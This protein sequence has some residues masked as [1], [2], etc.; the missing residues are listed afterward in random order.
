MESN[1]NNN[2]N[3]HVESLDNPNAFRPYSFVLE[4][5]R[6]ELGSYSNN[7]SRIC[8]HRRLS[9]D[10]ILSS[11]KSCIFL[12]H[13]Y[14]L[15]VKYKNRLDR[16]T[17]CKLGF[18]DFEAF[19]L[20][21]NK[22]LVSHAESS[23][24]SVTSCKH[25]R[26]F[27]SLSGASASSECTELCQHFCDNAQHLFECSSACS[28]IRRNLFSGC[29]PVG[30]WYTTCQAC[31]ATCEFASSA[32]LTPVLIFLHSLKVFKEGESLT[33]TL[34]CG[35]G[36]VRLNTDTFNV[37]CDVLGYNLPRLGQMSCDF[38]VDVS[39]W[40]PNPIAPSEHPSV[41]YH[42]CCRYAN[43]E[44]GVTSCHHTF[45]LYGTGGFSLE[46]TET[47]H[48]FLM[49][50]SSC[51][52]YIE[53][54]VGTIGL[55]NFGGMRGVI[56]RCNY[57]FGEY[58]RDFFSGPHCALSDVPDPVLL[59][60]VPREHVENSQNVHYCRAEMESADDSDF[61]EDEFNRAVELANLPELETVDTTEADAIDNFLSSGGDIVEFSYEGLVVGRGLGLK[62]RIGGLLKGVAN[63]IKKLHLVW[64]YP[65]DKIVDATEATGNWLEENKSYVS[66][67]VWACQQC[68]EV[69]KDISKLAKDQTEALA[70]LRKGLEKLSKAVD[71]VVNAQNENGSTL[72]SGLLE[73]MDRI[74][75]TTKALG[76]ELSKLDKRIDDM[77]SKPTVGEGSRRDELR[78]AELERSMA[79]LKKLY[80]L[81]S[82]SNDGM[83]LPLNVGGNSSSPVGEQ[84][85]IPRN[86]TKHEQREAFDRMLSDPKV[87]ILP[88]HTVMD[89][90]PRR[91]NLSK[92]MERKG[93][94]FEGDEMISNVSIEDTVIATRG[95]DSQH[96]AMTA[97]HLIGTI[98]W[99][100]SDG[101]NNVISSIPFPSTLFKMNPRLRRLAENF[102]YY[103][104][105]GFEF[106]LSLTSVAMQGGTLLVAWDNVDSATRQNADT[107]I[108]LSG[109]PHV[110]IHASSN[111][112][113]RLYVDSPSLQAQMCSLGSEYSMN[114]LGSLKV[115]C[116]N[117]LNAPTD[118]SQTVQINV[119]V[120]FVEPIFSLYGKSA[121][122]ADRQLDVSALETKAFGEVSCVVARGKWTTTS[123]TN[124]MSLVVHPC[125]CHVENQ[126]VYQTPL[127]VIANAFARWRG[128]LRYRF[129]FGASAF[130]KGRL[131]IAAV[132]VQFRQSNMSLDDMLTYPNEVF[133]LSGTNLVAEVV[134]PYHS[135]GVNSFVNRD[136]IYDVASYDS[137]LVTTRLHVVVLDPLVLNANASNSISYFVDVRPGTDFVLSGLCGV[138]AEY[139]D[140]TIPQASFPAGL[141][142]STLIG[143][144]FSEM[145][146]VRSLLRKFSLDDARRNTIGFAVSPSWR[147]NAPCV[148]MLNWI[149]QLFTQWRGDLQYTLRAHSFNKLQG[150]FVR[151]W[152]DPNGSVEGE[153]EIEYLSDVEPSSGAA[154]DYWD[155]SKGELVFTVP[156]CA[157]TEKLILPKA[158]Y[159]PTSADWIQCYNG[160]VYVDFEGSG[161]INLELSIAG[162]GAFEMF[163]R[164]VAP[165]SGKVTS[166]FTALSY[167]KDLLDITDPQIFDRKRLSGPTSKAIVTPVVKK[168]IPA[169]ATAARSRPRHLGHIDDINMKD[170]I[171][172]DT[173]DYDGEL[174]TWDGYEWTAQAGTQGCFGF[175]NLKKQ[176]DL[177]SE[178]NTCEKIV[179]LVENAHKLM[180]AGM[181]EGLESKVP[182]IVE[183]LSKL[184]KIIG[185][186][187]RGSGQMESSLHKFSSMREKIVCLLKPFIKSSIPGVATS[188][189]QEEKYTWAAIISMVGIT[190]F[191]ISAKTVKS[192]KKKCAIFLMIVWA[193]FLLDKVWMLGKW[194]T[195]K[196]CSL[197]SRKQNEETCR[198]SLQGGASET[199]KEAFSG[200]SSWLSAN[201]T[202]YIKSVFSL[203]G[204]ITSLVVWGKIPSAKKVSS[205]AE[206]LKGIGDNGRSFTGII[207]GFKS[208]FSACDSISEKLALWVISMAGKSSLNSDSQLQQMVDF[209]IASWVKETKELSLLENKFIGFGS[210]EHL[211]KVRRLYDNAIKIDSAILN[212]CKMDVALS[213]IVK[214]CREKCVALRNDTY[215]FK[216]MKQPRIDPIHYCMI[217]RP[218]VGK[219]AISHLLINDIL[220]ARNEP[221]V[222]RIY[223]RCC[224]D[225]YWSNY[226]QEP[227]VLYDDLGAIKSSLRLSDFAEI[228]GLKTNDPF[229]VPMAIAE[230]KGKHCTSK[231]IFSC[232][233]VMYLDDT[234]DVVTKEA[235]YR[236]R[237]IMVDVERDPEVPMDPDE[238]TAG[239]MFTV[240]TNDGQPKQTWEESFLRNIDTEDWYFER[241]S[242]A[243]FLD[244]CIKYTNAYMDSQEKLLRSLKGG[245]KSGSSSNVDSD[246]EEAFHY[247]AEMDNTITVTLR[248]LIAE[249]DSLKFTGKELYHGINRGRVPRP[250][251]L[252][253]ARKMTLDSCMDAFCDC[254]RTGEMCNYWMTDF[255]EM[256]S[257]TKGKQ[258]NTEGFYINEVICHPKIGVSCFDT[259]F[260][261]AKG[262]TLQ[263]CL[264]DFQGSDIMFFLMS[265]VHWD[266]LLSG[267]NLCPRLVL[268]NKEIPTTFDEDDIDC[269]D[270]LP[271]TQFV[272]RS[273]VLTYTWPGVS[274]FFPGIIEKYGALVIPCGENFVHFVPKDDILCSRPDACFADFLKGYG[275][276]ITCADVFG[277]D[278]NT[279][280]TNS[281]LSSK[282]ITLNDDLSLSEETIRF[283]G[284]AR[285]LLPSDFE[286]CS[287]LLKAFVSFR[288]GV[289]QATSIRKSHKVDMERVSEDLERYTCEVES[290]LSKPMKIGLA[291]AGGLAG[292]AGFGAALYFIVKGIGKM[293]GGTKGED[294]DNNG[295]D[296]ITLAKESGPYD[297]EM[298]TK[299]AK[300]RK[301]SIKKKGLGVLKRESNPYEDEVGHKTQRKIV[302]R[303]A[304][305]K[306]IARLKAQ[307]SLLEKQD[308]FKLT[309]SDDTHA[310]SNSVVM[311]RWGGKKRF[312]NIL[313]Q[314]MKASPNSDEIINEVSP[315]WIANLNLV[316]MG[317]SEKQVDSTF[318]RQLIQGAYNVKHQNLGINLRDDSVIVKESTSLALFKLVKD[319]NVSQKDVVEGLSSGMQAM[320]LKQ[321]RV[322]AYG[323]EKDVNA[324]NLIQTHC[325][326]MSCVIYNATLK[327]QCNVLRLLGTF[328]V[329]PA[330]YL[331]M[332]IE[333]HELYFICP[334]KIARITYSPNRATLV[335][336]YQDLIVWDLGK[337]VPPSPDFTKHIATT[338]DWDSFRSGQG[339]LTLTKYGGG[340]M[341]Q[342]V[343]YLEEIEVCAADV[344]APTAVYSMLDGEHT[345]VNGLRYRVGSAPGFCGAAIVRSDPKMV[346]KIV[347]LHV[348]GYEAASVGYAE[349]LVLEPLM[350]AMSRL[351]LD[352]GSKLDASK[353]DEHGIPLSVKH[354]DLPGLGNL[355][356][357]GTVGKE[358][359]ARI[360]T[361]TSI[362]PSLIHGLI[363]PI[364]TEPAI[365]S[366]HDRRL[367]PLKGEWNPV[368]DGVT[369]YGTN[370]KP[371]PLSLILSVQEHL[372]GSF[373]KRDNS[374]KS[375]S[376]NNLDVGINGIDLSDYW[377]P[378][379]MKTSPG[380]PYVLERPSGATGKKYLFEEV[381]C[382]ASGRSR[383]IIKDAKLQQNFDE[384]LRGLKEGKIPS[385]ITLE[386][387]KD[388]RRKLSKIYDKPATR[389]FTIL[390]CEINIL[391]RM[392]FGDF[393]AMV[394]YNRHDS[395][396]QVGIDPGTTEWSSLMNNLR[397]VGHKGFAGDYGKFDGIGPAEIYH[398]IVNVVNEWY[399]DGE[400][401]ATVRHALISGIIHRNGL[402]GEWMFKYSQGM[403]SGFA[404]TVIFN[405]FVN[406][407][408]M[409]MAWM[410]LVDRSDL[411]PQASLRDFDTFTK[412]IVYGDDNVVAVNE[413]FLEVY[414]LRTVSRYLSEY[415]VTYTDD[416]KN[417]IHLSE[418]SVAIDTVTF[419]KREFIRVGRGTTLWKAPLAK[420]SIEEQCCWVRLSEDPYEALMQNCDNA[421]YEA[422][423]HGKEY[424]EELKDKLERACKRTMIT[425]PNTTYRSCLSRWWMNITGAALDQESVRT[426]VEKHGN[427][428]I[429]FAEKYKDVSTGTFVSLSKILEDAKFVRLVPLEI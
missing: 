250:K 126:L 292:V 12:S 315:G 106:E 98:P 396:C 347:G 27:P 377:N 382:Y 227:V 195:K 419:L 2:S 137:M 151:V 302:T 156:Y 343:H 212:G 52:G 221:L 264:G 175:S 11:C 159:A 30:K 300:K 329:C 198:Y 104:C 411:G 108:Q 272:S 182:D 183:T 164:G 142:G 162:V 271:N 334:G 397:K 299:S 124:L 46:L 173:C 261:L 244:F 429:S 138:K 395:F 259:T 314:M 248:D 321:A 157:R 189:W 49:L 208:I 194:I 20:E 33:A 35:G 389:T 385:V 310:L 129:T 304:K 268:L 115:A 291:I 176:A 358:Y 386:C 224:A 185:R 122:S 373:S 243:V 422:S 303:K 333:D 139:I 269:D 193:P 423:V 296:V 258:R 107:F 24:Y 421:L 278:S 205:F 369:K 14:R 25:V 426:L 155:P 105:K 153:S 407:Y 74:E 331:E 305:I 177:L 249:F 128:S 188:A 112:L 348:A 82:K 293:F 83:R 232:T 209:N 281:I 58:H 80:V 144:G 91:S 308:G 289:A 131:M 165:K 187:D 181:A 133:S 206:K 196:M 23:A 324:V 322:G 61:D 307:I 283:F 127:S 342:V 417:P 298:V 29:G 202:Q 255:N 1:N 170:L 297:D 257:S 143:K 383:F 44:V 41:L 367:G 418:P 262:K 134:V 180:G 87:E 328:V 228:M 77:Q 84:E 229:T 361:K 63:C 123:S 392:Y 370:T 62:Q 149:S 88:N 102:Q 279:L 239:L 371:F 148:T 186:F 130:V 412:L 169:I 405:S 184:S 119:W 116:G 400:E 70:V 121:L 158:R 410:H 368:F 6:F 222:D 56:A 339:A 96:D 384:T 68:V 90:L 210:G 374:L 103:T 340:N 109:L 316:P 398:S 414:N 319:L 266:P 285:T 94:T 38:N 28:Q 325:S 406:Y 64:D 114:N 323:M 357:M 376:V 18:I 71:S 13:V 254:R 223:T 168:P 318:T 335:S 145:C 353:V 360:P 238:P 295:I 135:I 179:D 117:V 5:T 270:L 311:R 3:T 34:R 65:L 372:I 141:T 354:C 267:R 313:A 252:N 355:G 350:L 294:N 336:Q 199:L 36:Y 100:V 230:E 8:N 247:T 132:P 178:S 86:F 152:Y 379:Q 253:T 388:E 161:S 95:R 320:V 154:V 284:K 413:N 402:A 10:N 256:W 120:R 415:G 146:N 273:G 101:E 57:L 420:V 341:M 53:D 394:M 136:A 276:N 200:M 236:R 76:D 378:I 215:S 381:E 282:P 207:G 81:M 330:H 216:G 4:H 37:L 32:S 416:A 79:L 73:F 286:F 366:T 317:N 220:N 54:G 363:G 309:Y 351:M 332:L 97:S 349:K 197:W 274:F 312:T 172:G 69:Q 7:V 217:G 424:F 22:F 78:I 275:H 31:F 393:A 380:F 171:K 204:V 364:R 55:C 235:Y 17:L 390:P 201:W 89:F 301:V 245:N 190:L 93:T 237:N 50:L 174:A 92:Q 110:I 26:P 15:L 45:T 346:R 403:P 327:T 72:K 118:S 234:G 337:N 365:L 111:S 225:A 401:C 408:F 48:R 231:Y 47:M 19:R 219:S 251:F 203:F 59:G 277:C 43:V 75:A 287:F 160:V 265:Y 167:S 242:Y 391:F 39:S 67:S 51:S 150:A 290:G 288:K 226:H 66:D 326:K 387:P 425:L 9:V 375:R 21:F 344:T 362:V 260:K 192:W 240:L 409:A 427:G 60:I 213:L 125:A 263:T 140:R 214:D 99:K 359:I 166:G 280:L 16:K 163:D 218:G 246:E 338:K 211:E 42:H 428:E 345:I 356:V 241:V 113:T 233:N 352:K 404:M 40:M 399:D 306:E 85:A 191:A 147:S